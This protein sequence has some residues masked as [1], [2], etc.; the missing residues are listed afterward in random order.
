MYKKVNLAKIGCQHS[1]EFGV[2]IAE[3]SLFGDRTLVKIQFLYA[4]F[5]ELIDAVSFYFPLYLCEFPF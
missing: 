5:A 4:S 3:L 1:F 2:F